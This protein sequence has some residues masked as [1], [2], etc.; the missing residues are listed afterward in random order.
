LNQSETLIKE[1]LS[2]KYTF[3]LIDD[4]FYREKVDEKAFSETLNRILINTAE[5]RKIPM[6]Q[7]E[8]ENS[9]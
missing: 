4:I 9:G 5:I 7:R 8:F 3:D 2:E 1:W 6:Q